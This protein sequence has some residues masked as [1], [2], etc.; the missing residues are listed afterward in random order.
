MRTIFKSISALL[1]LLV[2]L[3]TPS[4]TDLTEMNVNP[5]TLDPKSISTRFVL[6]KVISA[7]IMHNTNMV[8]GYGV[9]Q[10]VTL[11]AMQY[12]QRDYLEAE[13][14]N[15]FLW[16]NQ[17][18]G[19]NGTGFSNILSDNEYLS[20]RA[21]GETDE[22]FYSAVSLIMKSYWSAYMTSAWGD[23]PYSQAMKA[24]DGILKPVYDEQ[25]LVFKG[26]L[27]DLEK[28]NELLTGATVTT[29]V[30]AADPLYAGNVT[31]WRQFA[32][33][34]QLRYLLRL[35]EKAS[36][37]QGVGVDVKAKFSGIVSNTTKYPI[38]TASAD[39]AEVKF[40]GGTPAASFP[41]G[42][43]NM[44]NRNNFYRRKPAATIIDF[45][46]THKDP[47]LTRW[48]RPVDVQLVVRST[49]T[50]EGLIVKEADG[51]VKR[52]LKSYTAGIDT[53]MYV[54]LPAAHPTPSSYN[55]NDA[56]ILSK[57]KEVAP[58]VYVDAAA[59]PFV[60]YLADSYAKDTDP[61]VKSIFI[62]ASEVNFILS[63]AAFKTW[64]SGS[65]LDYYKKGITES[66]AQ[67]SITDGAQMVYNPVNHKTEAFN[68]AAFLAQAEAEYTAATDKLEPI[69]TQAWVAGWFTSD[70]WFSWRKTAYPNL[71]KN[72]I[73]A[74]KGNKIP[75]RYGYGDPE[76][77][78]NAENTNAAITHLTPAV[79]DQWSKMWLIEGTGKPWN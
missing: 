63:E 22:A 27:A 73:S 32:N 40:P 56:A 60:S 4:C 39:N 17:A 76:K 18:W 8:F 19:T 51:K 78:R 41:G 59:N 67:Y 5:N 11:E 23:I 15:T 13:V 7:S 54:G 6:S 30:A 28:A 66:L 61:L 71:G 45:L 43:L 49:G 33:S 52:Y 50:D 26:I 36:D 38:I 44:T 46:K 14:T 53:S 42:P 10:A 16:F 20:K 75:V 62:T 72:L 3:A 1:L 70:T 68:L 48:I 34:L 9:D 58:T 35:S 25:K 12:L 57:I 2:L 77:L 74:S 69:L 31:K 65:A 29:L 79:D 55:K 24:E 21:I 37:M 47:R 64:I